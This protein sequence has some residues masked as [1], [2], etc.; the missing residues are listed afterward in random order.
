VKTFKAKSGPF[1]ERPFYSDS[2]I[3]KICVSRSCH[4]LVCCLV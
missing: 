1:S 3:E 4:L 2:D